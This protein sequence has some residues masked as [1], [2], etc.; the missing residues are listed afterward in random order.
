MA[1]KLLKIIIARGN[2]DKEDM[3]N[4]LDAYFAFGRITTEE[5]NELMTII[6][7]PINEQK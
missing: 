3:M 4:K 5:Y 1:Y 2:Y 7:E 6:N